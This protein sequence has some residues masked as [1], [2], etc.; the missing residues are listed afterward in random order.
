MI[1]I[2]KHRSPLSR[3]T[4]FHPLLTIE[5]GNTFAMYAETILSSWQHRFL[6]VMDMFVCPVG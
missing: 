6:L 2:L 5:D 3:N 1:L 4:Y